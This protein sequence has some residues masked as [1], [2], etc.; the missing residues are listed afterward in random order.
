M[1]VLLLESRKE[2]CGI[3]QEKCRFKFVYC[4]HWASYLLCENVGIDSADDLL[5]SAGEVSS[6]L[7]D[8]PFLSCD[9]SLPLAVC[10]LLARPQPDGLV[11]PDDGGADGLVDDDL[12][13]GD[14]GPRPLK[15]PLVASDV[16][17]AIFL[18]VEDGA[19]PEGRISWDN[20]QG[21]YILEG[22]KKVVFDTSTQKN[23]LPFQ[24]T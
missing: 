24:H 18:K 2:F 13:T 10:R 12:L 17:G 15:E 11:G 14:V 1:D 21:G 4:P 8:L 19:E 7:L 9:P 20:F 16:L 23:T 3:L 6:N 5:V 22:K